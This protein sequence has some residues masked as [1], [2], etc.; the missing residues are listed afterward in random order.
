MGPQSSDSHLSF[1]SLQG[2]ERESICGSELAVRLTKEKLHKLHHF[3]G[4]HDIP[5]TICGQHLTRQSRDLNN[6]MPVDAQ[7]TVRSNNDWT[8]AQMLLV[9]IQLRS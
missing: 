2:F 8:D 7:D 5:N 9:Q 4:S 6:K 3:C 1:P